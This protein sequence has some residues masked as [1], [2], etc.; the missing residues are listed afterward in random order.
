MIPSIYNTEYE[1]LAELDD[2][3]SFIWTTRY[4]DTGDFELLIPITETALQNIRAGYYIIRE[5]DDNV[6]IIDKIELINRPDNGEPHRMLITGK[7]AESILGRRIVSTRQSFRNKTVGQIIGGLI[8]S[9]ITSPTL[10]ARRIGNFGFQ[11]DTTLTTTINRQFTGDN[12]EEAIQEL[13][14]TYGLGYKVTLANGTWTAH[15]Y[16][17][18]NRSLGQTENTYVIFSTEFENLA[19][20]DYIEDYSELITDVLVAGEGQGGNRVTV[21]ASETT[22]T[23]LD[24]HEAYEDARDTS[25]ED[26]TAAEYR[27][28]L[29]TQGLEALTH[30]LT[31]LGGEVILD[32]YKFNEDFYLGDIVRVS[33]PE[34]GVGVDAR[35]IEVIESTSELGV[36]TVVPTFGT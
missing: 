27:A 1:R 6:G 24:R 9:Q 4:Y 30:I 18:T 12:V 3:I 33:V 7:L 2:Y 32:N 16:E 5:D 34:W 21:W 10:A 17:G 25:S 26:M 22:N 23:G 14:A 31:A 15:L 35:I 8:E 13:C 11:D 20:V 36:Y 19:G 28:Q 29:E